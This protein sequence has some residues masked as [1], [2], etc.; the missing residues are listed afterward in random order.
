M[1][2]FGFGKGGEKPQGEGE[3]SAKL[4]LGGMP[5]GPIVN[6]RMREREA[7]ERA[8]RVGFTDRG[9]GRGVVRRKRVAQP[10]ATVYVKG[11]EELIEWFIAYT[12][13]KGHSAY[14]KAIEDFRALVEGGGRVDR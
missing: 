12:E 11:P 9:Q 7:M 14:W 5:K 6:D 13:D 8:E 3:K 1:T 4:D 10:T 2:D